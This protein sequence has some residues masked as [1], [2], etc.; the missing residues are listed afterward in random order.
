MGFTQRTTQAQPIFARHHNVQHDHIKIK[1]C[2]DT[3]GVLCVAGCSYQKPIAHQKFL[4][5]RT[6]TFVIVHDQQMGVKG[7][8]VPLSFRRV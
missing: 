1:T 2:K 3:A 8:H 4:Q 5:Q 7:G 6:D